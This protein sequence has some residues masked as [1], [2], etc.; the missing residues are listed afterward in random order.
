MAYTVVDAEPRETGSCWIYLKSLRGKGIQLM[1]KDKGS[2]VSDIS[3]VL[4]SDYYK[5]ESFVTIRKKIL[6]ENHTTIRHIYD[7]SL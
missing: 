7:W 3:I 2:F 5:D 6:F 1:N 4:V